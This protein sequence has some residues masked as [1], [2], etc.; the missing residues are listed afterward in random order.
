MRLSIRAKI[1]VLTVISV[2]VSVTASVT[3][4]SYYLT[5][6]Y[7]AALHSR[8]FAIARIIRVQLERVL[9]Y[10]LGVEDLVGFEA[11]LQDVLRDFDGIRYA[12]VVD[13]DGRVL[14][15]NEPG[16]QGTICTDSDTLAALRSGREL[17]HV[18]DED[19]VEDYDIMVPVTDATGRHLATV[20]VGFP[21]DLIQTQRRIV[22]ATASAIGVGFG[23][24]TIV[25]LLAMLSRLVTAPLRN[26]LFAVEEIRQSGASSAHAVQIDTNDEI[27]RLATSFNNMTEELRFTTVSRDYMDNVFRTLLDVLIVAGPDLCIRTVNAAAS[28]L[29][30]FS[31]EE[32]AGRPLTDVIADAEIVRLFAGSGETF[33]PDAEGTRETVLVTKDGRRIP[34][35]LSA[36]AMRDHG[37]QVTSIVCA[38][39]D[40]TDR[41]R[42][43]E[44][45]EELIRELQE[46]LAD[47]KELSG[48]LPICA[49]CKKIRD[50]KGYWNQIEGYISSRSKAAFSHG[51]CPDCLPKYFPDHQM[52]SQPS[53]PV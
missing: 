6:E 24:L 23:A 37:G 33:A 48:L 21:L 47:V 27:G 36:S 4:V 14:F 42:A 8:S 32:F 49:S 39:M 1:V 12:M 38:A 5:R 31:P 40:I 51:L 10:G 17:L 44:Q 45:R 7:T 52:K 26:L 53:G 2:L 13:P 15:H 19:A 29:L 18:C 3:S 35:L 11:Q 46:A 50:D 30:G 41:K 20:R 43:E 25:L 9:Q 22:L 28:R 34:V 16:F